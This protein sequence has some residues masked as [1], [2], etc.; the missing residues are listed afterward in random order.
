MIIGAIGTGV[1]LG[2]LYFL[3]EYLKVWYLYAEVIAIIIA[4]GVNFN[5]NILVKNIEI[6]KN[7]PQVARSADMNEE[8]GV[9]PSA[10][11]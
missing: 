11:N 4:F 10:K 6:G 2:V 1:N 9:Q 3:V 7:D 8:N 5:G